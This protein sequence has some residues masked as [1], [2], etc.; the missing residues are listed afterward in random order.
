MR[1]CT[2]REVTIGAADALSRVK[3]SEL[4]SMV[5]TLVS[6]DLAKKIEASWL[7]DEKLQAIKNKLQD[8]Q[9]AKKHYVWSNNQLTR[10]GKIIVGNDPELRKELL[11][12]FHGGVVGG[13]SGV[14][15]PTLG[16]YNLYLFP[17]NIWTSISMDFIEGLPKSQGKNVILVVV[18]RLSK[19]AH[20]MTLAHPFT[21]QQVAQAFLDNVYKLHGMP[22]SIVSD[23][24]KVFLSNFWSELFK[25][26]QVQLLKFT[27]YH[28]QTDGQT[29]V[30]TPFETVYEIPPPIRV[31]YLG[32]LSKVEAV[33]R[34]L[35]DREEF[36]QTLKFHLLRTHNR[37]KQQANKGRQVT[38]RMGKQHKFSPK[39]YGPFK[40]IS[41]VGQVAYHLELNSQAQIH[42]VFHVSQL[43]GYKGELP[44]GQPIDIPLCDSD[45]KLATQPLKVL[46]RKMV[47]KKNDVAVYGLIQWTNGN[48]DDATW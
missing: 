35:K 6:T 30:T 21:A 11:Q 31:P 48:V 42:N 33:D 27:S 47:K 18:D 1:W 12:Y 36:I 2:K 28:P 24:D 9:I 29:K 10:K 39:Y 46:D 40:V 43:K 22:E 7:A 26:L 45:G 44:I 5:T 34:T 19:Y 8:G 38:V 15:Q 41:R 23:R 14:K 32:G 3:T 13:H 17:H 20:F 37:M 4:F 16:C 25:L